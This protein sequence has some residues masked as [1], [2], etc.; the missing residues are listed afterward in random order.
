MRFFIA[1]FLVITCSLNALP[2]QTPDNS[3]KPDVYALV[4]G[5]SQYDDPDIPQLQFANRDA[6]IFADFLQSKAGG[7]VPKANIRLLIDSNAT[8]SA[9]HMAIRWLTRTCK[10]NDL[11]FF[12][13]SGHGDLESMSMFNN[14][15][16]IC[17][18]T[19]LESYVGM[20]LSVT[21]LNEI[22]NTL[23]AQTEAKVVLITDA[24]HS[25]K[26]ADKQVSALVG[27]QLMASNEKEVRIASCE[28]DQ[29]SN[30]K[31]DWGGGRGVFSYYLVNG[32]K[33]LADQSHDGI[34]SF[35]EIRSYLQTSLANDPVL[36]QE[37]KKQ[38]PVLKGMDAFA[39]SNVDGEELN[40]TKQQSAT[41]SASMSL[42]AASPI[43]AGGLPDDPEDY[44]ISLLK[45]ESLESLTD[46]LRLDKLSAADIPFALLKRLREHRKEEAGIH[47]LDQLL[48][49]LRQNNDALA[50]IKESLVIAFDDQV[51]EVINQYL[52]GDEAEL[53]RRRYYNINSSGYDVYPKMLAVALR[54][55]EP[56][57]FFHNILQVKLHYFTG[58]TLRLKVPVTENPASLIDRA[59]TEQQQALHLEKNAA[60]IYNEL[61][62]LYD[63]KKNYSKAET[64]YKEAISKK[65]EW[66]LPRANLGGLYAETGKPEQGIAACKAAD[67]LKTDVQLTMV[68][69]GY[70]YEKSGNLLYA[71]EYYRKAIDLNAR[72]YLPFENLGYVYMNTTRYALADSFFYEAGIRKK[73]YH[74]KADGLRNERDKQGKT[75]P[76]IYFCSFEDTLKFKPG[77]MLAWFAW[78]LAK[79][80]AFNT[81]PQIDENGVAPR[82]AK[83]NAGAVQFFKKVIALGKS[84]PLVYHYLAIVYYEQQ[85][86]EAAEL[87]FR[88]ARENYMSRRSFV[89]YLDSVKKAGMYPYDHACYETIFNAYYY[90]QTEDLYFLASLYE[91]W[92]RPV[93]AELCYKK[94]IDATP[95]ELSAYMKRWK[96]LEKQSLYAE[97]ENVLKDA[98]KYY[99]DTIYRELNAF[100]R[101][102]IEK[103]P[104]KAEWNYKL[105]LLLYNHAA[106]PAR[107]RYKDTILWFPMVNREIFIPDR[108]QYASQEDLYLDTGPGTSDEFVPEDCCD[109]DY[110]SI[111][112]PGT[113]EIL[114]VE[115]VVKYPRHDGI[116]Y[117]KQAAELISEKETLVSINYKIAEL[118]VWAGSKKMALPYF[119]RS[120]DLDTLNVNTRVKIVEMST[121]VYKNRKALEQLRYLYNNNQISF[122]SR[123][124][125]ARFSIYA[126][127]FDRSRK[128]IDDAESINPYP[129]PEIA[130]LNGQ[131]NA[132]AGNP[133]KAIAFYKSFQLYNPGD[134]GICYTLARLYA[135]IKN[136]EEALRWLQKAIDM[137]F[138]Y[139][140]VLQND[141][142]MAWLRG[143]DR[144]SSV[145][146]TV[147]AKSWGKRKAG[148]ADSNN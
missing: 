19:P 115:H 124:Q 41:D 43:P 8:V 68:N 34:V 147:Q 9:V 144:W 122:A 85:Q 50:R 128:I 91:K 93:E 112:V 58:V 61:G 126:G 27:R 14:A 15:Y 26:M 87:M 47:K 132:L 82:V 139:V 62:V 133:E 123:L 108:Y 70:A 46:I 32:L 120:L 131:F 119:E 35:G 111:I 113:G 48:N 148:S 114:H 30:E 95:G 77:D 29:L 78:G 81:S 79:F 100:Y 5:I 64:Y 51:Q 73:G 55:T 84:N 136:K 71:E 65:P 44:F 23:S 117:L 110:G 40:K 99:P 137:G 105:G 118:Y 13:F 102:T 18:N 140:S 125:L 10:K 42:L 2:Q 130:E 16:L 12:Y 134:A 96:L 49:T 63:L 22:A 25:G 97:A 21:F 142:L 1:L 89:Q 17:Y 143:T 52:K 45:K 90:N 69:M 72:H 141:P 101:R 74:F 106:E 146:N 75:L 28:P 3:G 4:V 24:C 38:T 53:E 107:W 59:L 121:A 37:N 54:L 92:G 127:Q 6:G 88:Y 80:Y 20:S 109:D 60:Y 39:L 116:R 83:D 66:A 7:S 56:G 86:W 104:G 94:I 57:S 76:S 31:T 36:R 138:N 135:G 98:G 33:G 11:V 103:E 145:V 129:L 67:S